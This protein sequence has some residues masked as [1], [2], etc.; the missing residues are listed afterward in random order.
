ML[1]GMDVD[2]ELEGD[3]DGGLVQEIGEECSE[4]VRFSVY[5]WVATI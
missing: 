5:D 4:K 2:A 3:Q 1:D